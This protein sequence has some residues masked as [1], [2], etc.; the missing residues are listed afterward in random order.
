MQAV[1]KKS[2]IKGSVLAPPSKSMAHRMLIC[3]GLSCGES[4]IENIA[5][6]EDI[7]ATI[8]CLKAL[9]VKCKTYENS[10]KI[11]GVN[12][13]NTNINSPLECNEC[14]STLRFFIPIALLL[15][16]EVVLRGSKKLFSRPLSIYQ[17]I[18][19]ENGFLYIKKEDSLVVKGKLKPS[20]YNIKGNISSQFVTGMLFALSL[21]GE[22]SVT[23]T[24]KVESRSYINLTIEA[25]RAFG[26]NVCF[27]GE[28]KIIVKKGSTFK[29]N[30]IYI[31]GD[32]S[33]AANLDIYNYIGGNIKI[34]GLNEN[35]QQGD[36][37][38]KKY[39]EV[40]KQGFN[41]LDISNCPDLG[42]VL[43]AL[44]SAL[45][46]GRFTGTARLKIKESDRALAM[47][48]ELS[49]FGAKL[50]IF[51]NEVVV[52]K[53]DLHKPETALFSHND[54][55]IVMALTAL[56]TLFGGVI[57]GVEAVNKS[58]P[59]FFQELSNLNAEIDINDVKQ[60]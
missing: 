59:N 30:N 21:L 3:A 14:G 19:K 51:A 35:S 24:T 53:A 4:L 18:A 47:Q 60:K 26:I 38:Y 42:P 46:G 34:S 58:Y 36:K 28:N 49:K 45:K 5:Y 50:E 20:N 29:A 17:D 7:L 33:N 37:I 57:N 16:K 56:L 43:F 32:Y 41:T 55:R 27:E 10:V 23:F 11:S 48:Q 22:G 52:E 25:L 54:H 12:I 15:N 1:V 40:L 31:E 2:N 6:S 39:F 44:A 9:G 13:F 8:N